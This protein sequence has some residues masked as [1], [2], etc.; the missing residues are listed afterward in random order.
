[1]KK[2]LLTLGL[3]TVMTTGFYGIKHFDAED[4]QV[5][6]TTQEIRVFEAH[7][8]GIDDFSDKYKLVGA[9]D[10][11]FIGTVIKEDGTKS[12][13]GPPET[14]FAV[15]VIENVKGNLS[16]EVK[17]N[18]QG[19]YF[20]DEDGEKAL[21]LIEGDKLLV[22]GQTYLFATRHLDSENW[23]T[24][25]PVVGDI[26]IDEK[27]NKVDLV[28]EYKQAYKNEKTPDVLKTITQSKSN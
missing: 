19:G 11:V 27:L 13:D 15:E 20:E 22:P 17:V 24:L 28:K 1:M 18:Q 6:E 16:G 9:V 2:T 8:H 5:Q 10:N 7:A 3:V 4:A 12:L 21:M 14:Q 26:L 25:V 23:N